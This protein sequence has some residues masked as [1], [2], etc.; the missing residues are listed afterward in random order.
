[1]FGEPLG[2]RVNAER[3]VVGDEDRPSR[4]AP[5]GGLLIV[6]PEGPCQLRAALDRVSRRSEVPRG[7]QVRVDVVVGDRTVLVRSGDPIDA[8]MTGAIVVAERSP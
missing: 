8:E 7:H 5:A 3:L 2:L 1:V 4:A 6:D